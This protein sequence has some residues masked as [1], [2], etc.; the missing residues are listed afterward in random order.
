M[1]LVVFVAA[2]TV[3]AL[4]CGG[5]NPLA[6]ASPAASQAKSSAMRSPSAVAGG[7]L[8]CR[9]PISTSATPGTAGF[10]TFPGGTFSV[11]P[12]SDPILPGHSDS[13]YVNSYTYDFNRSRWLP[14]SWRAVAGD[15]SAY[16]YWDGT[17]VHIFDLDS[18]RDTSLGAPPAGDHPMQ[19]PSIFALAPE[20]VYAAVGPPGLWLI[21]PAGVQRQVTKEGYWDAVA[22]GAGWG[23]PTNS[24]PGAGAVYSIL[25]LDLKTGVSEPWFTR[26]G[27]LEV[28]GVDLHGSPI[29]MVTPKT[30]QD[31]SDLEL[32]IVTGRNQGRRIYSAPSVVNGLSVLGLVTPV[33]GD[34]HGI[35]FEAWPKLYLY[36]Q[37]TG[38]REMA[39]ARAALAGGCA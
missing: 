7:E 39:P 3:L 12:A 13:S 24:Y 18:G 28:V 6:S 20:G 16:A 36:S 2:I 15:G 33:I 30:G 10:I 37:Q 11:D 9:L 29:V 4:S 22:S 5:A 25:R 38:V 27:V 19:P 1:K 26:A 17:A 21:G 8:R 34:S 35:W 14:T 31:S 32:W 23:R